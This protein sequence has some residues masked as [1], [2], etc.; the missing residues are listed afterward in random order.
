MYYMLNVIILIF[1]YLW[2]CEGIEYAKIKRNNVYIR[3][4]LIVI[5]I[6]GF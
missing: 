3:N 5:N 4:K 6:N 1:Y 2:Y